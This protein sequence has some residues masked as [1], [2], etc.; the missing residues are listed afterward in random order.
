MNSTPRQ[1]V[2][3]RIAVAH[4]HDLRIAAIFHDHHDYMIGTR[5]PPGV[6][7]VACAEQQHGGE[8][9]VFHFEVE[10]SVQTHK[11]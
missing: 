9:G 1:R 6:R 8:Q 11:L 10:S 2:D 4:I 7:E 5:Q 3:V